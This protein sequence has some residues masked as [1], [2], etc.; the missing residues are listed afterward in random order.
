MITEKELIKFICGI[1]GTSEPID[2]I[3]CPTNDSSCCAH[4]MHAINYAKKQG[5]LK[6][7]EKVWYV[8]SEEAIIDELKNAGYTDSCFY[9]SKPNRLSF[10]KFLFE[11]CDKPVNDSLN[12]FDS[13]WIEL[14][15][16]DE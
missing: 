1:C 12:V 16:V 9:W 4:V 2:R 10:S 8:K 14:R 15:E 13:A 5:I 11:L 7:P 3:G 6:P